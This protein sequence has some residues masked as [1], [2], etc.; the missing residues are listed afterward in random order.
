MYAMYC[1]KVRLGWPGVIL[2][3]N[4]A[5]LS[6]DIF[7]CLLQ[8]CDT[9]S[10][11]TQVEEPTKPET[12]IDEEFPGEFE[13][14]S[15]PAEEAEK[16]VH[17]DKSS[18]K[19]ASSSTVVSNMK[20]IS[21]VKVVKIETDSAD[22]MKRI[23]DSLNHYEALGLP[24]FKKIDAALLKKDYR[25][26]AMLVH[27]DKNMGS[28]LASES[29]KKLQSAYEVLS[30]SVKRRDYDELLKKEESR[31]KIV[32][33]SSHAS[34]HQN[35]A[36][37]RSEESRRIH[38]TKCG[39]SHIWVCTNR[40]KAK[41]RWCQEC[42]QYHQAKD[43]D[44]WVEHKGTLVFEKAHK[45]EIPRAFVCAEGKVF[46]VSEWAIC[47][48]MACRPNTHRPSFHVNMVG[49][50]KATQ[51]SKSS[52]FPWD[53]DVEMMD[54]DEEE[55]ELWLQQALASGLF[56]ETSKR[57]KSWSPFKLTKKQ[58]RRTST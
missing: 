36:A 31:T 54:E 41:A 1:V 38:C 33:Q 39:N 11:K 47:Q 28:P 6:N 2:S 7:I 34:S 49:L 15:V 30:D 52:R 57:R 58:S 20:E 51:R 17:E 25:K 4:L 40:S 42:G 9:V 18:T 19:P 53:L 35:S 45:I 21:T 27:P 29:F 48:G 23:L 46:D 10:E 5:F 50:E 13:Y 55:F 26:K 14:S 12:V 32:C 24:L 3:M 22:E 8:W 16:K 43:G 56:C 44:G 37:Y